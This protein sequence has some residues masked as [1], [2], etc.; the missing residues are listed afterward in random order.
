MTNS[1]DTACLTRGTP[2]HGVQVQR[3]VPHRD[4][5]GAFTEIFSNA[6]K[7]GIQPAQWSVVESRA[8]VFRGMHLHHRHDE[9]FLLIRGRACVG[10]H[11]FRRDSPTASRWSVYQF[12]A[13]EPA[14][15]CF[16]SG[17]LHG[18]Y[19]YEDSIHVQ[20]VSEIYEDYR[21]DD[22]LG[23]RWDDLDLGIEWPFIDPILSE[24]ARGF[25]SLTDLRK[26]TAS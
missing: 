6:W 11:D 21:D 17:L 9:S 7:I 10:L 1:A 20:A 19:F 25:G 4:E 8:R 23:C 2:L 14:L 3:L 22:N 13:N 26:R 24:E 5:R 15:I 18:W 12:A 16:P